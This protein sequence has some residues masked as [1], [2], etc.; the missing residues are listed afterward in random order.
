MKGLLF[1]WCCLILIQSSCVVVFVWKFGLLL[2]RK[3]YLW[4]YSTKSALCS[5][6]AGIRPILISKADSPP[7]SSSVIVR[8]VFIQ[9][10]LYGIK[11]VRLSDDHAKHLHS[12]SVGD[13]FCALRLAHLLRLPEPRVSS[14]VIVTVTVTWA[15]ADLPR[16][17]PGS[18]LWKEPPA[19]I[20]AQLPVKRWELSL[21]LQ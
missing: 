6:S 16:I 20:R 13:Y 14:C 17:A 1:K 9:S 12:S 19:D 3:P 18:R 21:R 4:W 2:C 8:L 5:K 15:H 7:L 11:T 10:T